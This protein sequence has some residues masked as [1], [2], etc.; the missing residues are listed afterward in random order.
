MAKAAWTLLADGAVLQAELDAAGGALLL[1][2]AALEALLGWHVDGATLCRGDR[3]L[4]FATNPGMVRD[5]LIDLARLAAVLEM[6]LAVEAD[7]RVLAL[8][9]APEEVSRTLR[10]G[11]APDFAL[12]DLNGREHRLSE[13]RGRKVLLVTWA[14]WCGCREDLAAW[15]ALHDELAPQGLT[16]ITIAQDNAKDAAPFIERAQAAH[17][18]LVD[19]QH[20]VSHR[21]GLINV[22]SAVWIDEQ[23]HIARPPRVEHATNL[24]QFAH[25]LDCEPHLAALRRWAA[26]GERDMPPDALAG[27]TLLPSADDQ[28]ARA[29][30]VLASHL[31]E[32]GLAGAAN[33]HW[34]QAVALAPYDWTI[35][36][37]SMTRRG[38]NPFGPDFAAVW[39]EWEKAGRPDYESLAADRRGAALS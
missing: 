27:K 22:P 5:G 28:Q 11:E 20:I 33:R 3:C 24:F 18:S 17:P 12:P 25:G 26:T 16:V 32:Q 6:P 15:S 35:R 13:H 21:F 39:E 38:Q 29:E 30:H 23:G 7:A 19:A 14:S 9:A 8:G 4:P 10:S 37:G 1:A 34:E 36:R 31:A 2:P